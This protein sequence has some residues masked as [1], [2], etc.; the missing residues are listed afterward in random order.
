MTAK[1]DAKKKERDPA[2]A[3]RS[4]ILNQLGQQWFALRPAGPVPPL[5]PRWL[6]LAVQ[7][8]AL[9]LVGCLIRPGHAAA[10]AY[11]SKTFAEQFKKAKQMHDCHE[12]VAAMVS[13]K[14]PDATDA[15][16]ATL[17]KFG[18]K[19]GY[20]GYYLGHLV[21]DLPKSALP[22][23]EALIP[24]LHD[25]VADSLLGYMQQLRDNPE[26]ARQEFD[27]I[28][29]AAD[30]GLHAQLT[31]DP[32]ENIAA[33]YVGTG[34]RPKVAILREQGVNGQ[35]EMA[36]AF[37]RATFEAVDVHM[38]DL[39]WD[40]LSLEGFRGLAACGGFSYGDVLGAGEGWAKSILLNSRAREPLQPSC[41][42]DC[43][44]RNARQ[45]I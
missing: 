33:P 1:V 20:Y 30:P 45:S 29:D 44:I 16:I 43:V 42:S 31:F 21:A 13:A 6:D 26:C 41:P 4:A 27:R 28:L 9:H 39:L 36:A 23:L 34:A 32:D 12:V 19:S 40:D 15:V 14:H 5:D 8:D 11:L 38:S 24:K 2:Y 25:R 37:D 10:N 22:R 18:D 7:I 17:E 35:I 3:K